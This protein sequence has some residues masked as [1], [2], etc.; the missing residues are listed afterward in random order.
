MYIYF[1]IFISCISFNFDFH[2][3]HLSSVAINQCR[4]PTFSEIRRKDLCSERWYCRGIFCSISQCIC[5]V[6]RWS[7]LHVT[8]RRVD[9][10]DDRGDDQVGYWLAYQWEPLGCLAEIESEVL[11]IVRNMNEWAC[12]VTKLNG[13]YCTILWGDY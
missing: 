3:N 7:C 6:Y 9:F 8:V 1:G 2:Q 13:V 4:Q 11:S 12:R 10:E 5:L